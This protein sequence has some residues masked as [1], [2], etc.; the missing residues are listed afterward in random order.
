M[1]IYIYTYSKQAIPLYDFCIRKPYKTLMDN[2]ESCPW[3]LSTSRKVLDVRNVLLLTIGYAMATF[4]SDLDHSTQV[5]RDQICPCAICS[6]ISASSKGPSG[7][8]CSRCEPETCPPSCPFSWVD[9]WSTC[10]QTTYLLKENT[11]GTNEGVRA[12]LMKVSVWVPLIM[13]KG[14]LLQRHKHRLFLLMS[15]S[16][17]MFVFFFVSWKL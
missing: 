1:Y 12:P 15:L 4:C 14:I 5:A 9:I 2:T 7:L 3:K 17:H 16:F 13:P 6:W 11:Q 8:D 10:G